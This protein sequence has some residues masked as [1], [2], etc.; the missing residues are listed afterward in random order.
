MLSKEAWQ[1]YKCA[2]ESGITFEIVSVIE[3]PIL[4]TNT[5]N[6]QLSNATEHE[7]HQARLRYKAELAKYDSEL[8]EFLLQRSLFQNLIDNLTN[9]TLDKHNFDLANQLKNLLP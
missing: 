3:R 8:K 1:V 2:I 6:L 5:D 9:S 7:F 4:V